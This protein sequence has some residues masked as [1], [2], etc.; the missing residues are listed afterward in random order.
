MGWASEGWTAEKAA[1]IRAQLKQAQKVGIG[2]QSLAEMRKASQETIQT[3]AKIAESEA[4][5]SMSLTHFFKNHFLPRAKREKRTWYTDE[6]R[7]F[8]LIDPALGDMPLNGIKRADVQQFIDEVSESGAAPSTAKQY[9][10]LLRR[11]FNVASETMIGDTAIFSG[12][13]PAKSIRLPAIRNARER[14]LSGDEAEILISA[15]AKL[16]RRDLHDAIII[17]LNTGLRLGEIRRLAWIDI[18]FASGIV[19]IRDEAQRKPG[20]TVPMNAAVRDVLTVRKSKGK[21]SPPDLVFPPVYG[22]ALRENMSH[23]FKRLVDSL[24]FNKG[25]A[26]DDRQKRI[27]FHS[28]RHTF[29]SWLA[30]AGVDIYRIKSLMRHK[31]L[32]MTMRYAH[33]IPDATYDAVHNLKPPTK[34]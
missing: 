24:G 13:N 32:D 29:A 27:V 7:F 4:A 14:F 34:G 25:L 26:D 19:T 12:Q 16:P 6:K 9:M 2:P 33:L 18:D 11:V 28:L 3:E 30:M 22:Q 15:A 17:S 21:T 5:L 31:T 8:K 20:G 10:A 23:D 1:T